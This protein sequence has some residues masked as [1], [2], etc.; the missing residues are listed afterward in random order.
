MIY[1]SGLQSFTFSGH[2]FVIIGR[3]IYR[4]EHLYLKLFLSPHLKAVC[5]EASRTQGAVEW[6][7]YYPDQS[8]PYIWLERPF[9]TNQQ[10][11]PIAQRSA[12]S[13]VVIHA[14]RSW[15]FLFFFC[16][17]PQSYVSLTIIHLM[18]FLKPTHIYKLKFRESKSLL[19]PP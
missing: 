16:F 8:S 3:L 6:S 18:F 5:E 10:G 9:H 19:S 17:L 2:P 7:S 14:P 4:T 13:T 12:L 15:I 11:L 1:L